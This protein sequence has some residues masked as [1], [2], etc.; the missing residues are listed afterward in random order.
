MAAENDD[1]INQP[2]ISQP[3][4]SRRVTLKHVAERAGVSTAA[5]SAAL[6]GR[7][8]TTR[9]SAETAEIVRK[10]AM[11][12][13]YEP[14]ALARGLV[15]RQTGVLALAMPYAAAFWDGNPFNQAIVHGA[16]EAAA[17]LGFNLMLKTRLNHAWQEWDAAAL[18]DARAD[19][20]VIVAAAPDHPV[21]AAVAASGYPA[22]A[23]VSDPDN[24]P[25]ACVNG[26]DAE[27]ARAAVTYLVR[28]G[29]RRIGYLMGPEAVA[30]S[31][32]RL[33][34]YRRGLEEAGLEFDPALVSSASGEDAGGFRSAVRLLARQSRPTAL[35]AF[36]DLVARGAMDAARQMGLE[37]PHQL[38]VVG[39]D[40]TDFAPLLQPSLTTVRYSAREIGSQ[41]LE[42]LAR[43]I[44]T[45]LEGDPPSLV[46]P[47]QLVVR[48]SCAP[49]AT[50]TSL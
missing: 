18:I 2:D 20:V 25:I 9:V 44:Q 12:L 5:A 34:G 29:H 48:E 43:L 24:C 11:D 42:C 39:F 38:S 47:T 6:T 15:T 49:P 4:S 46:V 14:N 41:A 37:V 30:T 33:E 36:N 7:R 3:S 40:D 26:D 8:G 28:L 10:A 1:T 19:G 45:G 16:S 22:V 27:G 31:R 50:E 21:L 32:T 17:R 13:G 23:A 35:L